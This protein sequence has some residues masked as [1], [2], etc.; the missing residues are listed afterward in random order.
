VK[1]EL[2]HHFD[3][4]PSEVAGTILDRRYQE[5][6]DP[7]G[8]LKSRTLLSQDERDGHIVRSVRCVLDKTFAGPAKG[9]LGSSD[10]A[11]VEESIWFPAEMTWRWTVVPEVAA[12]I[13]SATGAMALFP[14]GEA[15]SRIV[16]GDVKVNVPFFGGRVEHAIVD[17]VTKVYDE[18]AKRLTRWLATSG[19]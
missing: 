15:T 11:W 9:I 7:I 5:S 19:A 3:A 2:Q 8:P 6:L 4:S 10:P 16:S 1:F 18:E 13:L 12:A 14:D 17:G